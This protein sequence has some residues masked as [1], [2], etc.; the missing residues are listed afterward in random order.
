MAR[1]PAA[2]RWRSRWAPASAAS[3]S[4]SAS[5]TTPSAGVADNLTLSALD[6]Y[7]NTASG[8]SGSH[9]LT[10]SGASSSPA[11]NAPTVAN[12]SGTAIAFG[13]ATA[14]SFSAGVASVSG[15]S[16]GVMKLYRA[17]A[18]SIS[19]SDGSIS[20]GSALA[21]TVGVGSAASLSLA[22]VT[23]SAGSVGV[24]CALTCT[25]TGLGNEGTIKANIGVADGWGN[26][27]SNLG[28]GHSVTVSSEGG[29]IAGGTLTIAASGTALSSTQFTY[30]SKSK[31]N[32]TDTITAASSS[33]PV[34]TSATITA[35]R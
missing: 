21:V 32:F 13:S 27:V 35:K 4:L 18:A 1:S 10:F 22:N 29:T 24:P 8:Y 5:S 19:V 9:K 11:G 12:S 34:Y 7:G 28:T 3:L 25:V 2:Q 23:L 30:T 17:A 26:L 20:S 14:L 31:G 33:G 6:A 16:N 15:T